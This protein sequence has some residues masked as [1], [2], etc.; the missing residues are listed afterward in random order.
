MFSLPDSSVG[1]IAAPASQCRG[2]ESHSSL[3]VFC[4]LRWS[5]PHCKGMNRQAE[6]GK[7]VIS[8]DR[9]RQVP[10][11]IF[12]ASQPNR[13]PVHQLTF[14]QSTSFRLKRPKR[15]KGFLCLLISSQ[16]V[17]CTDESL[18]SH[19]SSAVKRLH[20]AM[21]PCHA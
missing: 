17:D 15:C 11:A 18:Q 14:R 6:R 13:K 20:N 8:P 19:V 5:F 10:L 1:K 7:I 2:F 9:F 3:D 16:E 21:A 4:K 12:F